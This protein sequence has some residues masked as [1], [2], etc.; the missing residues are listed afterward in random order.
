MKIALAGNPNSGKTTIF[1]GV[2]GKMEYVG[3]WPGV[4]VAKKVAK[5]KGKYQR[6]AKMVGY[7]DEILVVDLPGAYSI[8]PFTGEEAITRDFVLQ[9]SPDAIINIIDTS[10][11]ERS[12]LFTTQLLE[13]G[14]PVV[15]ALNKQDII[16]RNGDKIDVEGISKELGCQVALVVASDGEGLKK[17][18]EKAVA[19]G[20][21]K[22]NEHPRI[23]NNDQERSEFIKELV[24]KNIVKKK[25]SNE[26]TFSDKVDRIVANVYLGIPIFALIMW[27][28]YAFSINGFGGSLSGYINDSLFGEI[29][30]NAANGFFESLG[31]NPLLQALIVDGAIGGVGAVLGFLPLIMILFFCLALLEDSGYMARVAVVMDR[32]F[33]RIGLSGKSIIP[34]IV[35]T[36]CSIPGIMAARTIENK[37]ERI[38]TTMLTPFVPCGAKLP[39]IALLAA[40]FFPGSTWVFPSMYLLAAVVIVLSGLLIKKIFNLKNDS[41]FIL[42]LPEYKIPSIKHAFKHMLN[43]AK[44]FIIKASTIILVMNTFVWFMQTYGWNLQVVE[45]QGAS[46]LADIGGLVAPLLIPLG[47]VGWQMAAATLTGFIAKENV[48]ATFA[49]ILA[50]S[51]QALHSVGGPL[52]ELF[53]PVTAFAFLVFNL[54]T[55]PCFAAIGAMNAEYQSRKWLT[56]AVLFQ[57]A[58]GYTLAMLIT[59]IGSLLVYGEF[60]IGFVPAIFVS[61]F[62]GGLLYYL[63]RKSKNKE[64]LVP[65]EEGE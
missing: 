39:I 53:T 15:I 49:I 36:G 51:D 8:A 23:F 58:V 7:T 13:L 62:M 3:N 5:L 2:T 38:A 57:L 22:K 16:R 46:I 21:E 27:A 25:N 52:T 1:N 61:M 48:V 59:Q 34:M 4:T 45:T 60:A 19:A 56:R 14:I 50:A 43:Q 10:N 11:L 6:V 9:E 24:I 26:V 30:P 32:Y 47:F 33:K 12:L 28:V 18:I 65:L 40:V 64:D 37:N 20:I 31:V 44:A 29:I 55:P 54:F 35:G 42:E 17:L 63:I 41:S